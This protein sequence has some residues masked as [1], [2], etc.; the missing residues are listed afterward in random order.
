MTD[1][2]EYK[3]KQRRLTPPVYNENR[4][5]ELPIPK[6]IDE[7]AENFEE[8]PVD[9][10][11]GIASEIRAHDGNRDGAQSGSHEEERVVD[12]AEMQ[13]EGIDVHDENHEHIDQ[14]VNGDGEA[15]SDSHDEESA[16]DTAEMHFGEIEVHDENHEHISRHLNDDGGAQSGGHAEEHVVNTAEIHFEGIV[17]HH[18]NY[19]Q[20]G[21]HVVQHESMITDDEEE[22]EISVEHSIGGELDPLGIRKEIQLFNEDIDNNGILAANT[23]LVDEFDEDVKMYYEIKNS[24]KP[25]QS[26]LQLKQNDAFSATMPFDF[27]V[28][29]CFVPLIV[30][31]SCIDFFLLY[32]RRTKID[33][34]TL[35][36][37]RS[38]FLRNISILC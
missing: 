15:Q 14:H 24:F 21:E 28:S 4:G 7:D 23:F 37:I 29:K 26:N 16:V 19:E 36:A 31:S 6:L 35:G 9:A 13:F 20:I 25:I 18:E 10:D 22:N 1:A 27:G 17:V 30:M 32:N 3:K 38:A 5:K 11:G 12:T 8:G 33:T 34:T 2:E